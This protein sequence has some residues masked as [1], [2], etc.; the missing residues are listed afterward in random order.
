MVDLLSLQTVTKYAGL[1]N[2]NMQV[3]ATFGVG[4]AGSA[5]AGA[6]ARAP[7]ARLVSGSEDGR[8]VL[9]RTRNDLFQPALNPRLSGFDPMRV[10]SFESFVADEG[11]QDPAAEAALRAE[12]LAEL[13]SRARPAVTVALF[14]PPAALAIARPPARAEAWCRVAGPP[15]TGEALVDEEI[16]AAAAVVAAVEGAAAGAAAAQAARDALLA[17]RIA[18]HALIVT[19]DSRGVLRVYENCGIVTRL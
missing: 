2:Q 16:A 3:R 13:G 19:A 11:C 6:R 18:C 7:A 15:G 14:A 9:W 5:A 1:R 4:P 12:E 17:R 10:R 8:V